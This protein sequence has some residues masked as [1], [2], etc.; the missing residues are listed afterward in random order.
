[1]NLTDQYIYIYNAHKILI[2]LE[3]MHGLINYI[4]CSLAIYVCVCALRFFLM[5]CVCKT[6][7][8]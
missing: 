5:D 8:I 4:A 3:Q 2:K 1:M 7:A 6:V